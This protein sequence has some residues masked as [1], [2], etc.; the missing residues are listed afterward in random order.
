MNGSD[1]SQAIDE[2]LA[3]ASANVTEKDVAAAQASSAN[4]QQHADSQ[5]MLKFRMFAADEDRG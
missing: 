3:S 5:D 1:A 4:M 2:L